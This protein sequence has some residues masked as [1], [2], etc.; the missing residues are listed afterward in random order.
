MT[1]SIFQG[2]QHTIEISILFENPI[3][4]QILSSNP[5]LLGSSA[6]IIAKQVFFCGNP[7]LIAA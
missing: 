1:I 7:F 4:K 5:S 2:H 3:L 6:G